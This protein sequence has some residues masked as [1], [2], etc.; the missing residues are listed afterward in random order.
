MRDL[1]KMKIMGLWKE[2]IAKNL[3]ILCNL[4]VMFTVL[5]T[6]TWLKRKLCVLISEQE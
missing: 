4:T 6:F 3:V 1:H 2:Y 5:R